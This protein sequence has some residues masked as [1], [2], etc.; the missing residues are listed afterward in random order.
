MR[1]IIEL[2]RNPQHLVPS[3]FAASRTA[4]QR[5]VYRANGNLGQLC[6]SV[7]SVVLHCAACRFAWFYLSSTVSFVSARS[8]ELPPAMILKVPGSTTR[9]IS[10]FKNDSSSG[11]SVNS[12]VLVSPALSVIRRKPRSSL[13]GRVTELISSRMYIWTTSSPATLLALVTSTETLVFP[14]RPIDSGPAPSSPYS[15]SENPTP[16]PKGNIGFAVLP[17]QPPLPERFPH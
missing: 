4:V 16:P 1:G 2:L 8:T 13:I 9:C 15:K 6:K 3:G 10:R 12:T 17:K 5:A 11:P 14:S 7:N